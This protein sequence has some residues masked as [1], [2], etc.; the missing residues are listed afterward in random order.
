MKSKPTISCVCSYHGN[1]P[2]RCFVFAG[3]ILDCGC[4]FISKTGGVVFEQNVDGKPMGKV[5]VKK[6]RLKK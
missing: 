6:E 5:K 2:I 1:Q 4:T 3:L